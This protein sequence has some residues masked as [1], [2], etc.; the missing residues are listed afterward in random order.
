[1]P[2]PKK[3]PSGNRT[4]RFFYLLHLPSGKKFRPET[5][6]LNLKVSGSSVDKYQ[7]SRAR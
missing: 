3:R 2:S 5:D 1:M 4:R 6:V 7:T